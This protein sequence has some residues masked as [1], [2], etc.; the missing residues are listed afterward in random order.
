MSEDSRQVCASE[1]RNKHES[2][3]REKRNSSEKAFR[4]KVARWLDEAPPGITIAEVS[5]AD[6]ALEPAERLLSVHTD[7]ILDD[8]A[9]FT[10]MLRAQKVSIESGLLRVID[11]WDE[12]LRPFVRENGWSLCEQSLSSRSLPTNPLWFRIENSVVHFICVVVPRILEQKSSTRKGDPTLLDGKISVS[13]RSAENYLDITP[14]QRQKL[15]K[16][17]KLVVEGKGQNRKITTDSLR[18]YLPPDRNAEKA[19]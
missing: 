4:A 2:I 12:D 19:N 6:F 7:F 15:M 3:Y 14:R 1:G 5:R 17:E 10:W 9:A 18:K 13:F 16:Q 8:L 11:H